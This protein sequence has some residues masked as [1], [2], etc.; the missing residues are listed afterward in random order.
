MVYNGDYP[1]LK[2][3]LEG[4]RRS[5]GAFVRPQ[6]A[7]LSMSEPTKDGSMQACINSS[8]PTGTRI[9]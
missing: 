5:R 4:F 3:L 9:I 6:A 8:C 2:A 1:G 7:C